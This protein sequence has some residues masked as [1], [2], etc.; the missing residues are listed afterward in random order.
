MISQTLLTPCRRTYSLRGVAGE[1]GGGRWGSRRRGGRGNCGCY[2]N[3][4][5]LLNKK[6]KETWVYQNGLVDYGGGV[7]C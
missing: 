5:N 3:E 1:W 6:L 4:K 2:I 7:C